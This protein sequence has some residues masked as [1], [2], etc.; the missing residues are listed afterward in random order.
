M[1]RFILLL[2]GEHLDFLGPKKQ[3]YE[4]I[5]NTDTQHGEIDLGF[6]SLN[7]SLELTGRYLAPSAVLFLGTSVSPKKKRSYWHW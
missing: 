5:C 2:A 7:S 4:V 3:D 6:L 1:E